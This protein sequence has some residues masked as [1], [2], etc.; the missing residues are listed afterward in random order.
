M[1]LLIAMAIV[2]ATFTLQ[3]YILIEKV[4][5]WVRNYFGYFYLYLGLGAVLFVLILSISPWGKIKLG[6][7]SETPA[8]N[9][10]SWIAMLY[11]AG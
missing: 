2:V 3:S 1:G 8:H 6:K 9:L 10:W 4:S 11:S 5:L 7:V